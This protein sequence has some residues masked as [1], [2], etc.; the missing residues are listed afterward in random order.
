MI[1]LRVSENIGIYELGRALHGCLSIAT[2]GDSGWLLLNL[3]D[4]EAP[5]LAHIAT[6]IR[7]STGEFPQ[8]QALCWSLDAW[9]DL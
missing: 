2:D 6:A 1:Q 9:V 4:S 8:V 5:F 7:T 3:P